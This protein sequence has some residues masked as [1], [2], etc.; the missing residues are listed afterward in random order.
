MQGADATGGSAW[1]GVWLSTKATG[2]SVDS[3]AL[4]GKEL[5]AVVGGPL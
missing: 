3:F 2:D 1:I 4:S 5:C